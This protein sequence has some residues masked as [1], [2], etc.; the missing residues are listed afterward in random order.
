MSYTEIETKLIADTIYVNGKVYTVDEEFHIVDSFAVYQDRFIAAGTKEQVM[1]YMGENT[2]IVDTPRWR[3]MKEKDIE[4]EE[5]FPKDIL[6]DLKKKGHN[7]S[8]SKN[9]N[10]FGRGEIIVKCD[11]GVYAGAT[12]PRADGAVLGY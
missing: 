12:E 4:V 11:N 1:C 9:V 8:V 10:S 5:N 2:K 7:I 3:W 6:E